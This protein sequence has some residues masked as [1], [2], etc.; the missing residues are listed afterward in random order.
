[1]QEVTERQQRDGSKTAKKQQND[2]ISI[3]PRVFTC[4]YENLR[5]FEYC[6]IQLACGG[7]S[8]IS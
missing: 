3:K 1:M 8:I 7:K 2:R 5:D 4:I 6:R